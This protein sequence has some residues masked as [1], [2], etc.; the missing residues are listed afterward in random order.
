VLLNA[1][2]QVGGLPWTATAGELLRPCLT[3]LK[4]LTALRFMHLDSYTSLSGYAL[5]GCVH[6]WL[7]LVLS[8]LTV[9][10]AVACAQAPCNQDF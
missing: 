3:R 4:W 1:N 9:P 10:A 2:R 8:A 6:A 5:M 7:L